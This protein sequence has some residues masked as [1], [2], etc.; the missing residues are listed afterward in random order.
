[1]DNKKLLLTLLRYVPITGAMCCASDSLL[2]YYFI[3]V[4]WLG[5]VMRL[6][7]LIAWVALAVY[8]RFCIFYMIL[9]IYIIVCDI[10][11]IIDYTWGI[12]VSDKGLFVLHCGLAGIT[13]ISATI[14]HVRDKRKHTLNT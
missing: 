8:F 2:S 1:M 12:P 14:A 13:F 4:V 3:D 6:A 7:F 5:Y 9:V 10:L 11:N